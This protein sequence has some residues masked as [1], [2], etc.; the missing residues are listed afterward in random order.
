[1]P[2]FL[3][4][5]PENNRLLIDWLSFTIPDYS[6]EEVTL[7]LGL[8][9]S[10]FSTFR[11]RYGYKVRLSF[12]GINILVDGT[13]DK[14]G[15]QNICVEMSG[16]GCR[17]WESFGNPDYLKI[18][19]MALS[20]ELKITRL[21]I[22]YDD[23][24][25]LLPFDLILK[26]SIDLNEVVSTWRAWEVVYSN[27]GSSVTYGSRQSNCY[28]RCYDKASE[29]GYC[30]GEHWVRFE[31][32]FREELA[33]QVVSAILG[34]GGLDDSLYFSF[35]SDKIRFVESSDDSNK[36]RWPTSEF[37]TKLTDKSYNIHLQTNLGD[38]YN[39]EKKE[40]HLFQ[41][42]RKS[43]ITILLVRGFDDFVDQLLDGNIELN[44]KYRAICLKNGLSYQLPSISALYKLKTA[45]QQIKREEFDY[46][47]PPMTV[48]YSN[49]IAH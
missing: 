45:I 18:F 48:R 39:L 14:L 12:G 28:A 20:G 35:L 37:W 4:G 5:L 3:P 31:T 30:S 27:K 17:D 10:E 43:M 1:M 11:G 13:P 33:Y 44:S 36:S 6:L 38:E 7:L 29:R 47:N 41:Q 32:V 40:H 21:D 8:S 23:F 16:Q 26:K 49:D 46:T 42:Y 25:G 24:Q 2:E 9:L 22:A 19:S 15:R 34:C